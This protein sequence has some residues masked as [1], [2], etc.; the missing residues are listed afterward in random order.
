[1]AKKFLV[2]SVV[3][4]VLSSQLFA[5]AFI[6]G[7]KTAEV[8]PVIS[9]TPEVLEPVVETSEDSQLPSLDE[10][11]AQLENSKRLQKSKEDAQALAD[12]KEAYEELKVVNKITLDSLELAEKEIDR[13]HPILGLGLQAFPY[14]FKDDVDLFGAHAVFG[15]RKGN[16]MVLGHVGYYDVMNIDD[17]AKE[18]I[19]GGINVAYEF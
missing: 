14:V 9:E 2:A 1:M 10:V 17:P 18:N 6:P 11:I 4:C 15:V 16:W 5:F 13:V 3:F 8:A 12:L 19:Y 7:K